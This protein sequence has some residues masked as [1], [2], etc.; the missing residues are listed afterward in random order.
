[1]WGINVKNQLHKP[2]NM[3]TT[4]PVTIYTKIIP[5]SFAGL[6]L[7]PPFAESAPKNAIV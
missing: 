1:V 6:D 7:C 5:I 3:P 2:V 4:R